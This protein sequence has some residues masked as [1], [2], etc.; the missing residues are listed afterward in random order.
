MSSIK[1]INSFVEGKALFVGIDVHVK[2]W[3]LCFLLMEKYWKK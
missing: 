3:S 2:T 1:D